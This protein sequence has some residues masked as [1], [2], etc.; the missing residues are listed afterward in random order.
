MSIPFALWIVLQCFVLWRLGIDFKLAL[1]D[2]AISAGL[3]AAISTGTIM[4][5][6][7]YKHGKNN[8]LYRF[9]YAI[10]SAIL[11]SVGVGGLLTYFYADDA[12]K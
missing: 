1:I 7:F 5:Y 2:A 8:R 6:S 10:G 3:L 12:Y 11:F 4:I 9:I